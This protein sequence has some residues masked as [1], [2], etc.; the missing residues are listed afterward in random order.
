MP[1]K[2]AA[3]AGC[4]FEIALGDLETELRSERHAQVVMCTVR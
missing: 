1:E 4:F 3:L 2:K